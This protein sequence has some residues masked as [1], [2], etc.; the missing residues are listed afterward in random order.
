MGRRNS[1]ILKQCEINAHL[2][3]A[4]Y[5]CSKYRPVFWQNAG[6]FNLNAYILRHI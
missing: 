3:L 6:Y 5:A 4:A 2:C 1:G